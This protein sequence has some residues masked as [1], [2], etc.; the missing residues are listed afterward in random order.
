MEVKFEKLNNSN[1]R[2]WEFSMRNYLIKEKVWSVIEEEETATTKVTN[3]SSQQLALALISL[4]VDKD[5][6]IHLLECK[7]GKEAW[8][9]LK[10]VYIQS[11]S[12]S[13]KINLIVELF[14]MK[15]AIGN[16]M[17]THLNKLSEI[18]DEL[19]NVGFKT[20]DEMKVG[21]LIKSI[22][23]SFPSVCTAIRCLPTSERKFEKVKKLVMNEW[24]S[25]R[26]EYNE[27]ALKATKK[28]GFCHKFGHSSNVCFKK[29]NKSIRPSSS[30]TW[31]KRERAKFVNTRNGG[32]YSSENSDESE[33]E[34][35]EIVKLNSARASAKLAIVNER[36][37]MRNK[38]RNVASSQDQRLNGFYSHC[39]KSVSS[40]NS[41]QRK[42]V[43]SWFIDSGATDH[44][45][46]DK[47][48][49]SSLR[50]KNIEITIADGNVATT[51]QI[52]KINIGII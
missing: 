36:I 10:S 35:S 7:T 31:N 21:A 9:K 43:N 22:Q 4:C 41:L 51:S 47:N 15:F 8:D 38:S 30:N 14:S 37:S 32:N 24:N 34:K 48:S 23:E 50:D 13:V 6:Q 2:Y 44:I 46:I 42:N 5:Q 12:S 11:D 27:I 3:A 19:K 26:D 33:D 29:K 20:E 39:F 40:H 16:D 1:Y 45:C 25:N 49:F 52:G 18:I 28:C 17:R